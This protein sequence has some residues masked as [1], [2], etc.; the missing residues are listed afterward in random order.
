M[1][2]HLGPAN[3]PR[4]PWLQG[5]MTITSLT[6]PAS[7][8]QMPCSRLDLQL[9]WGVSASEKDWEIRAVTDEEKVPP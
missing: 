5:G 3:E 4:T 6:S 9:P 2:N 1:A 7:R 8:R